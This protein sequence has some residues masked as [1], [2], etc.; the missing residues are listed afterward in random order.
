M[1]NQPI[2]PISQYIKSLA[3]RNRWV[4]RKNL[5]NNTHFMCSELHS[6]GEEGETEIAAGSRASWAQLIVQP[7]DG[8][9]GM[10]RGWTRQGGAGDSRRRQSIRPQR[11]DSGQG[12][13]NTQPGGLAH[14]QPF[15]G[16][17][18]LPLWLG[19]HS[20]RTSENTSLY[21]RIIHSWRVID[22]VGWPGVWLVE[23][24]TIN[25]TSGIPSIVSS[26]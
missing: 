18:F 6:L 21:G 24:P 25:L 14:I 8:P 4:C 13:H 17:I 26:R 12:N 19:I 15:S 1:L 10:S 20:S 2:I 22:G 5:L 3:Y 16:L 9:C 11:R 23:T 7:R